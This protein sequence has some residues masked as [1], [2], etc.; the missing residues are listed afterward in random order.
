MTDF[1]SNNGKIHFLQIF[2]VRKIGN[3]RRWEKGSEFAKRAE[4]AAPTV[5]YPEHMRCQLRWK[6]KFCSQILYLLLKSDT[7]YPV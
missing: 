6:V 4:S 3:I 5:K 7:D 1:L 2:R